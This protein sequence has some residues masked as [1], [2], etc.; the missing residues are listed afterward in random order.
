M[1][2]LST[3]YFSEFHLTAGKRLLD[4]TLGSDVPGYENKLLDATKPFD[5]ADGPNSNTK[6]SLLKKVVLTN[7]TTFDKTID[8]QG[9]EKLQEFRALNTILQGVYFADGAPLHTVHLPKTITTLKLVENKD[10]TKI[11]T[12]TPVV[13]VLDRNGNAVYRDPETYKGLYL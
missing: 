13:T 3:S 5:I 2:D 1:G 10:L 6:K 8:V 11:L 7:M 9:S 12:N 4:L